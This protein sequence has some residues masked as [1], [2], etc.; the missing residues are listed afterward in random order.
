MAKAGDTLKYTIEVKN[1][2][3]SYELL[4]SYDDVQI[5]VKSRFENIAGQY[6]EVEIFKAK[7]IQEEGWGVLIPVDSL[8]YAIILLPS[9]TKLHAGTMIVAEVRLRQSP[10]SETGEEYWDSIVSSDLE[11]LEDNLIKDL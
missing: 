6:E 3:G 8:R 1:S 2:D 4:S 5:L 10:T 11:T 9:V 7:K